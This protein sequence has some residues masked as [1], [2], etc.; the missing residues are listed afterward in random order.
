MSNWSVASGISEESR[1]A[2][3]RRGAAAGGAPGGTGL[4]VMK[5][6]DTSSCHGIGRR[7]AC[8]EARA[9]KRG[10]HLTT[11]LRREKKRLSM[12]NGSHGR[13][14]AP[15]LVHCCVWFVA[16]AAKV[17]GRTFAFHKISFV[18]LLK[19]NL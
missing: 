8:G 3:R 15:D 4:G 2:R 16:R 18:V 9:H 11:E 7:E 12:K 19:S 14:A 5:T 17:S 13:H 6:F 10:L 1:C